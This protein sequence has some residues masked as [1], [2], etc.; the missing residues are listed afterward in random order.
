MPLTFDFD[1]KF[2]SVAGRLK[3]HVDVPNSVRIP[4]EKDDAKCAL[5]MAGQIQLD[6]PCLPQEVA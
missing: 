4:H 2:F 3:L 1:E 5:M 6:P